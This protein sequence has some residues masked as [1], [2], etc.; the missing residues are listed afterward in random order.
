MFILIFILSIANVLAEEG[1]SDSKKTIYLKDNGIKSEAIFNGS[2]KL[3]P[4]DNLSKEFYID[5]N[6]DFTC[7]VNNIII[8][9]K[10]YDKNGQL[11][12]KNSTE[13]K[14]F[15]NNSNI[16]INCEGKEIYKDK[17]NNLVEVGLTSDNKVDI[18]KNAS[19]KFEMIYFLDGASDN[20]IMGMEYK[21]D[22]QVQYSA[23]E[24]AVT[25]DK[26]VLGISLPQTGYFFDTKILIIIGVF[27]SCIGIIIIFGKRLSRKVK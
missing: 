18:D 12:D 8:A 26:G 23:V 15:M 5:N 11:L 17:L 13:Y 10:L 14:S 16:I 22:I 1:S 2:T 3:A 9:G 19:K 24:D 6:N 25:I 20:S 7:T 21:F 4:G 27:I